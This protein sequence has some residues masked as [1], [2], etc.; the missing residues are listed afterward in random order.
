[1]KSQRALPV[2][3]PRRPTDLCNK[4]PP[5]PPPILAKKWRYVSK[6]MPLLLCK[7]CM[8][9]V[10]TQYSQDESRT[11]YEVVGRLFTSVPSFS[12]VDHSIIGGRPRGY[13]DRA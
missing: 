9:Q 6:H 5:G 7:R 2:I 12:L 10:A 8:V 4:P 13:K 1:M 11:A 3:K